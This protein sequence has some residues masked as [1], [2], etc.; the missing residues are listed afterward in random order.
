MAKCLSGG[1]GRGRGLEVPC[2]RGPEG[3]R[4]GRLGGG[5]GGVL[6]EWLSVLWDRTGVYPRA[7]LTLDGHEAAKT[8]KYRRHSRQ[9]TELSI[10]ER[11]MERIEKWWGQ[12]QLDRS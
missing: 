6:S 8:A 12:G 3:Q 10:N 2:G 4:P 5:A 9:P 11:R 1:E 7:I